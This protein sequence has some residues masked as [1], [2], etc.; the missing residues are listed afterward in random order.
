[1]AI[2]IVTKPKELTSSPPFNLP[3]LGSP[4]PPFC[5]LLIAERALRCSW[6]KLYQRSSVKLRLV[7]SR[8]EGRQ[9]MFT[10][11][12]SRPLPPQPPRPLCPVIFPQPRS[13]PYPRPLLP[14]PRFLSLFLFLCQ[15][16][17]HPCGQY[18]LYQT[19]VVK[20]CV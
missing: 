3:L 13:L 19:Q 7:R 16:S 8:F 9:Y 20:S 6:L 4:R 14:S 15:H 5:I 18:Y 10:F 17:D 1:M 11:A 12:M 2:I